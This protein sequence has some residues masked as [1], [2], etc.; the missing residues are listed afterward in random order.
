MFERPSIFL[1]DIDQDIETELCKICSNILSG[2]LGTPYSVE[3]DGQWQAV[4]QHE[5]LTGYEES[6]LI[7]VDLAVREVA[8]HPIG[9]KHTPDSEID[10]WAKCD[11]G[12][13]DA[14]IRNALFA[15]ED[16]NKIVNNGGALVVFSDP[17]SPMDFQLTYSYGNQLHGS[18]TLKWGIWSLTEPMERLSITP[19][20]GKYINV[21]DDGPLGRLIEKYIDGTEFTCTLKSNWR[22]DTTWKTLANNKYG[23][24]VSA[25]AQYGN[26]IVLIFPQISNKA[27]FLLELLRNTLPEIAPSLFPEIERGKWTH[28]P[29][30]EFEEIKKLQVKKKEIISKAES[31]LESLQSEIEK[32]RE[33]NGW[34]HN[35]LT[36]T[37]DELAEAVKMS[38]SELGFS[39]VVDVD[40]IRDAEGK[41]RRED[42][43]IEDRSPWLVV[44]IK[45]VGGKA[46]DEDV[47]QAD[48]HARINI[49]EFNRADIQGLSIINQQRHLP[50]LDRENSEPFRPEIL[51]YAEEAGLGIMTTF[52]LYRMILNKR[53]HQ[54]RPEWII[55]LFY[56]PQRVRI[57]PTHYRYIG[58]VSKVFTRILGIEILENEVHVGDRIAIE[59]DI[60]F[61]EIPI[62]SIE[63]DKK[64]VNRVATGAKAG[65][66]W[67][68]S[69][70]KIRE[71]MPVYVIPKSAFE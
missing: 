67:P 59:G 43:R 20:S 7:I 42:L 45:G 24:C 18:N 64:Q 23:D 57:L 52:D 5:K 50:P 37:G 8:K 28:R 22:N 4:I 68:E 3:L 17:E 44:D 36:S 65:F 63:V 70:M 32:Y 14:R 26:G 61:E 47:M 25:A 2:T 16:I 31:E 38:L 58:V 66:A 33:E 62:D 29:E 6:D 39:N 51:H 41:S 35:L 9:K 19:A 46:G 15:R 48:K 13:I 40:K 1:I 69:A 12:W 55:P 30:Y 53:K 34:I 11:K 60:F 21:V 56:T 27:D 49:R 71:G 54:W 10:I